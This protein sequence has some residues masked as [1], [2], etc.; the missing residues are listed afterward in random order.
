MPRVVE[1]FR[2]ISGS[3]YVYFT[4]EDPTPSGITNTTLLSR[5]TE[6]FQAHDTTIPNIKA[7]WQ[8]DGNMVDDIGPGV[9]GNMGVEVGEEK[10]CP[11]PVPGMQA[12]SFDGSTRIGEVVP[13]LDIRL[14]GTLTMMCL[15][16]TYNRNNSLQ[17]TVFL[18]TDNGTDYLASFSIQD[19]NELQVE[20]YDG[21]AQSIIPTTGSVI[22]P[23]EWHHLAFVRED[24]ATTK[25]FVDGIKI[26]TSAA[27]LATTASTAEMHIGSFPG[28][29]Q[30]WVD[31][32]AVAS[33][34][35]ISES[36]SD[37]EVRRWSRR[38]IG[39][40]IS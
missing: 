38:T 11:S 14:S 7:L 17:H 4:S 9:S 33:L 34:V 15:F 25:I 10:Y 28:G 39:K 1:T 30:F 40:P 29:T 18:G 35:V 21:V 5:L 13:N 2:A 31:G 36:L 32:G 19:G 24:D 37:Q 16:N 22:S 3:S 8:F 27:T 23:N 20:Y 12:F 6:D 26:F